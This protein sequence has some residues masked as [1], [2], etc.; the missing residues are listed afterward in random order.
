MSDLYIDPTT[1]DLSVSSTGVVRLTSGVLETIA[2][3]LRIKLRTFMGEWFLDTTVG[4]PYYQDI[5]GV[6][7]P[8]LGVI[9]SIFRRQLL[10]DPDVDSVPRL[11]LTLNSDRS[12]SV[13]I[14]VYAI[15]RDIPLITAGSNPIIS[16]PVSTESN[17]LI[18]FF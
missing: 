16:V 3:R 7:N 1:G 11:D 15:D 12:L 13:V 2:Q 9:A 4:V 6:K 14:D 10:A 18:F 8:D 5:L 17:P